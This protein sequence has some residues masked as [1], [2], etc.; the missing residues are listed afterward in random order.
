MEKDSAL[1]RRFQQVI[2]EEPS[3]VQAVSI[4]KGLRSHY[5][6]YHHIEISD[7]AL[8]AAVKLSDRY[9]NDR[10]LPDKAID[11][12]DEASSSC[13]GRQ[14]FRSAAWKKMRQ[15]VCRNWKKSCMREWL[16]RMKRWKQYPAP[17]AEV[18]SV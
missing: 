5:E 13:R 8:E 12:I 2:V 1:D 17:F 15:D 9:I 6:S 3:I 11:L 10:F 14:K 7:E 4:L 18:V 16:D